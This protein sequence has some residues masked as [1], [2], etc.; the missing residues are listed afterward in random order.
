MGALNQTM[1]IERPIETVFNETIQ[2]EKSPEIMDQVISVKKLT[3]GPIG[4]GTRYE[5][6]RDLGGRKVQS[7]LVVT[8]FEENQSYAVTS[9][10]NGVKIKFRYT[11][12][13]EGQ[14]S[15]FVTFDGTITTEGFAR[16][17]FKGMIVRMI[18]KEEL[19]H[20]QKL[21]KYIESRTEDTHDENN[22]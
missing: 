12:R 10:Q 5:E 1:V 4:E 15:T 9:E 18:S 17:L 20:L 19:F 13:E 3:E 6:V 2:M 16:S 8:E 21:K 7:E 22:D 11:F 14:N